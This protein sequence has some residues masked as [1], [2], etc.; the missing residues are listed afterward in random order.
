MS[1]PPLDSGAESDDVFVFRSLELVVPVLVSTSL[2]SGNN[3]W[4]VELVEVVLPGGNRME[5]DVCGL[6]AFQHCDLRGSQRVFKYFP[7]PNRQ[8][9]A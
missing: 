7:F 9:V 2:R 6:A 8:L 4:C 1:P 5:S 3:G